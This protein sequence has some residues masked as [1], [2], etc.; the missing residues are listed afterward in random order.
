MYS[1]M[2]I[3]CSIHIRT[4]TTISTETVHTR[5]R[6]KKQTKVEA[7]S[8]QEGKE[9]TD[10]QRSKKLTALG[11]IRT[12]DTLRS[13]QVVYQLRYQGRSTD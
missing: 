4:V 12:H 6:G 10:P 5:T 13:R 9:K 11:E 2:T 3:I 7:D 8:V 1:V